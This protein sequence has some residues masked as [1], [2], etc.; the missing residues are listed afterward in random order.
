M[1]FPFYGYLERVLTRLFFFRHSDHFSQGEISEILKISGPTW[2]RL[3]AS[4]DE[5][6]ISRSGVL[7]FFHDNLKKAV[8]KKYLQDEREKKKYSRILVDFFLVRNY[9]IFFY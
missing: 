7:N 3:R 6:L 5:Y 2:H 4:L 1:P 9:G 8:E